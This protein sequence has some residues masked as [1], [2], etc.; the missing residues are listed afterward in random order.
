MEVRHGGA[1]QFGNHWCTD[2]KFD[3]LVG[4]GRTRVRSL[5]P[6]ARRAL[7][8]QRQVSP[9]H[10]EAKAPAGELAGLRSGSAPA[11]RSDSV[12]QRGGDRRLARRATDQPGWSTRVFPT[13]HSDGAGFVSSRAISA[14]RPES[15]TYRLRVL[16]DAQRNCAAAEA[17]TAAR[18]WNVL[19]VTGAGTQE[20]AEF[21]M[22]AAEAIRR[23]MI[24]E[25]AHT[26]DAALDAAV[27]PFEP[28]V[29]RHDFR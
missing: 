17:A 22:L 5:T 12:V 3:V 11:R 15:R 4:R 13:G 27:V 2:P 20:V 6:D 18:S 10:P 8:G 23:V 21:I 24:L 26:S 29:I 16:Q 9:P 1:M 28:V 7:Q 14:G 19:I 25:A